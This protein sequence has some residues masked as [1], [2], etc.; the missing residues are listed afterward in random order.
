[1][2]KKK[3]TPDSW[4]AF[5]FDGLLLLR[6]VFPILNSPAK[7]TPGHYS[8]GPVLP[9]TPTQ[10]VNSLYQ[11]LSHIKGIWRCWIQYG[12]MTLIWLLHTACF[13]EYCITEYWR[14]WPKQKKLLY[15]ATWLVSIFLL[16]FCL[17]VIAL[18]F[19]NTCLHHVIINK[20]VITGNASQ[21]GLG[22]ANFWTINTLLMVFMVQN[23][24]EHALFLNFLSLLLKFDWAVTHA[25]SWHVAAFLCVS[26]LVQ[27]SVLALFLHLVC[28]V[29]A[30]SD[31]IMIG[32]TQTKRILWS[33][34]PLFMCSVTLLPV[35]WR[36]WSEITLYNTLL[37]VSSV[38][39]SIMLERQTL[40][41]NQQESIINK[42]EPYRLRSSDYINEVI[43]VGGGVSVL[44][45]VILAP[46]LH[47][48][49]KKRDISNFIKLLIIFLKTHVQQTS[50]NGRRGRNNTKS[51]RRRRCAGRHTTARV[52]NRCYSTVLCHG[53]LKEQYTSYT[54]S[55]I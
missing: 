21:R 43:G 2:K 45:V 22:I 34:R 39:R 46:S 47:H 35:L 51:T 30:L 11:I 53:D 12:K 9:K 24:M 23:L 15:T 14:R 16:Y 48:R 44:D 54:Y 31:Y 38:T 28:N 29:I 17:R 52:N 20:L 33:N 3:P 50:Q 8:P 55:L 6:H 18:F 37:T 4:V 19:V 25:D 32:W 42:V 26:V 13:M 10:L 40:N 5:F 27:M 1:M 7:T 49:T 36:G 41:Q